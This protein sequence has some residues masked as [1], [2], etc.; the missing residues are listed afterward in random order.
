[1]F[2][3]GKT[4]V[5]EEIITEDFVCNL[6]ACKGACC[7]DGEAGAPLEDGETQILLDIYNRVK[8]YLRPEGRAAIEKDGVYVRGED[9]EWET[10]LVNNNECAYVT[11]GDNGTAQ[12]GIEKAYNDGAIRWRKPLSCHLYPVRIKEYTNLVAVNYHKWEICDPACTLGTELRVPI[13]K[14]VREALIRKFG[15]NWYAELEAVARELSRQ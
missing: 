2:Q 10:P 6:N 12:C 3:I 4:I 14:F 7:V 5:S 1:M 8:G 13:Y 9:G 11:F 15:K